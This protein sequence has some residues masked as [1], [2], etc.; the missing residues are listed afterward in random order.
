MKQARIDPHYA[1]DA[2]LPGAETHT[3]VDVVGNADDGLVH[4][5][6]GPFGVDA[7]GL[8]AVHGGHDG[9]DPGSGGE[10]DEV[11]ATLLKETRKRKDVEETLVLLE[12]LAPPQLIAADEAEVLAAM[13]PEQVHVEGGMA[14]EL[15]AAPMEVKK[16]RARYNAQQ[17]EALLR[18]YDQCGSNK[19][20]WCKLAKSVPGYH[21]ICRSTLR[22]WLV[23]KQSKPMGRRVDTAF[24]NDVYSQLEEDAAAAAAVAIGGDG[25]SI[26]HAREDA[27]TY[28]YRAV[29]S[30]AKAVQE[31][32]KWREHSVVAKLKFSNKWIRNF[33]KRAS[34]VPREKNEAVV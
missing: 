21:L 17:K 11:A 19:S 8:P 27:P 30:A 4:P 28:S 7:L 22:Y 14:Y 33:L 23:P 10:D 15:P 18:L 3:V 6:A 1:D 32:D 5:D 31:S 26:S 9:S 34:L 13:V 29:E 25:G 12:Q 20:L 2:V 16:R 24:E